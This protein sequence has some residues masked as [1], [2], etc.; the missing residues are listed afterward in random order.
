[1]RNKSTNLC[2]T[3]AIVFANAAASQSIVIIADGRADPALLRARRETQ[4]GPAASL[5]QRR[6][7]F[8][9]DITPGRMELLPGR[10]N[11]QIKQLS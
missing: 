6:S 10:K 11:R 7:L 8:H 2:V 4:R 9:G 1:M 3:V 5:L